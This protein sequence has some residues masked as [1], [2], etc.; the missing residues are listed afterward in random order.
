MCIYCC[1]CFEDCLCCYCVSAFCC[2]EP[3]EEC[4]AFFCCFW[5]GCK[6]AVYCL[7]R[8]CRHCSAICIECNHRN[9]R[10]R[11]SF[12]NIDP[13]FY[14]F[15]VI[16]IAINSVEIQSGNFS[17][18]VV[19]FFCCEYNAVCYCKIAIISNLIFFAF[20]KEIR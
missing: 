16:G 19:F 20:G 7:S 14:N 9:Y 6:L 4:K 8:F 13:H 12:L 18:R 15:T 10:V 1:I 5:Q 17:G 11:C 2:C 3:A